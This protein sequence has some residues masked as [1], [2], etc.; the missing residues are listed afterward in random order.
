MIPQRIQDAF[1]A[2]ELHNDSPTVAMALGEIQVYVLEQ[3]A[4]LER[5]LE[6][7]KQAEEVGGELPPS[8]PEVMKRGG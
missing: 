1:D 6:A 4:R 8:W 3:D 5:F 7:A 2:A